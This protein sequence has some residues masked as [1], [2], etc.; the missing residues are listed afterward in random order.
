MASM[1]PGRTGAVGLAVALAAFLATAVVAPAATLAAQ[2]L[3]PVGISSAAQSPSAPQVAVDPDGDA[4][5][6][7]ETGDSVWAASRTAGGTWTAAE[8]LSVVGYVGDAPQVAVDG[9]G[10]ATAVWVWTGSHM[11][12]VQ[13]AYRP[14]GGS[15]GE[16]VD[17]SNT[18]RSAREPQIDVH[19]D[20]RAVAVWEQTIDD[21]YSVIA[22]A[23]RPAGGA[24]GAA[25]QLS[26]GGKNA[27]QP[28]VGLDSSGRPTVVWAR[29]TDVGHTRIQAAG[30]SV[31]DGWEDLPAD[32]SDAGSDSHTPLVAVGPDG[33]ATVIWL[34]EHGGTTVLRSASRPGAGEGWSDATWV[35]GIGVV[36]QPALAVDGQ[37]GAM[38]VWRSRGDFS[39]PLSFSRR[40]AGGAWEDPGSVPNSGAWAS[41]PDVALAA[42][43]E[44][45]VAWQFYDRDKQVVEAGIERDGQWRRVTTLPAAGDYAYAPAVAVGPAGA[46]PTAVWR[47]P[48]G[49]QAS[50]Y[51]RAGPVLRNLSIPS[52]A[53]AGTP[54]TFS[55][56]PFD[57]LS[58]VTFTTWSIGIDSYSGNS[59]THTF[60]VIPPLVRLRP[61]K[62]R[63]LS[64]PSVRLTSRDLAGNR[65]SMTRSVAVNQP[66]YVPRPPGPIMRLATPR[67]GLRRAVRSGALRATCRLEAA[68]SCRV[69]AEL[70]PGLA[71]RLRIPGRRIGRWV[72]IG[73]GEAAISEPGAAKVRVKLTRRARRAL[74]RLH[75]AR[76]AA[77]RRAVAR[78]R[79]PRAKR[80]AR[81]RARKAVRRTIPIR[82][83]ARADMASTGR[84]AVHRLRLR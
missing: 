72:A 9:E 40:P 27:Y 78:A 14:K 26:A 57:A 75:R 12:I 36:E 45:T 80:R 84:S 42:D 74:R 68:G 37:G 54:V 15:W 30:W 58:A 31:G 21:T 62:E 44:A 55:V 8:K 56:S 28:Q 39:A 23:Q 5:A 71:G 34:R 25:E 24:W 19:E 61:V 41:H 6:V 20:G 18:E 7:W 60:P 49:V 4:V 52:T 70:K 77:V 11:A 66:P 47:G 43:G 46:A 79:T 67:Q 53:L 51:D 38:A 2:W 32:I 29:W 3:E 17:L 33:E 65:T 63:A 76:H 81:R 73:R 50:A 59:V 16:P 64:A 35:T 48:G 10:N 13:A 69:R 82:L 22:A 1:K 83:F